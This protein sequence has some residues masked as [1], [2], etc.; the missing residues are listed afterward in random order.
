MTTTTTTCQKSTSRRK[1]KITKLITSKYFP[2]P[3]DSTTTTAATTITAKNRRIP[4]SQ[5][6]SA[7]AKNEIGV[8]SCSSSNYFLRSPSSAYGSVLSLGPLVYTWIG[9]RRRGSNK[10]ISIYN[11]REEVRLNCLRQRRRNSSPSSSRINDKERR[12]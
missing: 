8:T 5:T 2:R 4:I 9:G 6:T 1:Q 7:K 10:R 11:S 12:N 3:S